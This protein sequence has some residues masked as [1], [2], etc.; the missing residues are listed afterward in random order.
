[1]AGEGLSDYDEGVAPSPGAHGRAH[2][3]QLGEVKVTF[4]APNQPRHSPP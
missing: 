2:L 3:S 1:M 4:A